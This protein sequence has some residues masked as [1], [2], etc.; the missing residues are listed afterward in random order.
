MKIQD[1]P[2]GMVFCGIPLLWVQKQQ[3]I[4]HYEQIPWYAS[5]EIHSVLLFTFHLMELLQILFGFNE[6]FS[7][8]S[9]M[10][11]HQIKQGSPLP[12]SLLL[13]KYSTFINITFVRHEP[14]A[15]KRSAMKAARIMFIVVAYTMAASE[16]V[17]ISGLGWVDPA[18]MILH[19]IR[20]SLPDHAFGSSLAV[21]SLLKP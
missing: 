7:A 6:K 16:W 5:M 9:Y 1:Y 21:G 2:G 17:A 8:S 4:H 3:K 11:S 10:V 20:L 19:K 18:E 15:G 14:R 12:T 13:R